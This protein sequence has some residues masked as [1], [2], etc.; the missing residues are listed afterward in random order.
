MQ[1][2]N[3]YSQLTKWSYNPLMRRRMACKLGTLAYGLQPERFEGS[4]QSKLSD[5]IAALAWLAVE[6]APP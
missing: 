3:H 4:I 1:S 5:K 2:T 6:G